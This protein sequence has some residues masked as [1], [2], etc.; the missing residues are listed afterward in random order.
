MGKRGKKGEGGG[1]CGR[2]RELIRTGGGRA[3]DRRLK[4][5]RISVDLWNSAGL[6]LSPEIKRLV[7]EF[8]G[9]IGAAYD[10]AAVQRDESAPAALDVIC[11]YLEGDVTMLA[12]RSRPRP[13][14]GCRPC[15]PMARAT[16]SATGR[17]VTAAPL[18]DLADELSA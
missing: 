4:A 14:A 6:D 11:S 18:A 7:Y 17:D 16:S 3:S 2:A 10:R 8:R 12:P 9:C 15:S 1:R 5:A 13:W